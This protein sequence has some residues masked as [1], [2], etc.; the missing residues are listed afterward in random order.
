MYEGG[1]QRGLTEKVR[2]ERPL[3]ITPLRDRE[4]VVGLR[5]FRCFA[6]LLRSRSPQLFHV[7]QILLP[8]A[9]ELVPDQVLKGNDCNPDFPLDVCFQPALP[10]FVEGKSVDLPE[11][12]DSQGRTANV[13]TAAVPEIGR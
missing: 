3:T 7:A 10:G 11:D 2:P 8:S 13:E 9:G 4:R 6:L 5:N 12:I 1:K